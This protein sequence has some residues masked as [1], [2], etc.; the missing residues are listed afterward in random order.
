MK[1]IPCTCGHSKKIHNPKNW[2]REPKVKVFANFKQD[3]CYFLIR[4]G[5][6]QPH[7]CDCFKYVPD[8]LSFIEKIAKKKG[9]V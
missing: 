8:N 1:D 3:A 4:N 7:L 2:K 5:R 6:I 9:L